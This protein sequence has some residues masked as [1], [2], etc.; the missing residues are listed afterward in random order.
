MRD[1]KVLGKT[2]EL[3]NKKFG[4]NTVGAAKTVAKEV[5][6]ISTEIPQIDNALII[7]GIPKGRIT[8]IYGFQ[9]VGKT[10]LSLTVIANT[11]KR[12]LVNAFVDMEHALDI[13]Y[14]EKLGVN[15]DDL[16]LSQPGTAEEALQVIEVLTKSGEVDI[17]WLDSVAA[18]VPTAEAEADMDKDHIGL[19]ARLVGKF[20]RKINPLLDKTDTSLVLLN[21]VRSKA[22]M[23][24]GKPTTLPAGN[25]LF[26][27]SSVILELSGA[28]KT[29]NSRGETI[30]AKTKVKVEKNK[31]GVQDKICYFTIR[32]GEGIDLVSDLIQKAVDLDIIDKSGSWLSYKETRVQGT[33]NLRQLFLNNTLSL[34]ELRKA[35]NDVKDQEEDTTETQEEPES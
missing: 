30:S 9:S 24:F 10:T 27:Y 22:G 20:C 32:Y 12:G 26:F 25:A 33:E 29:V 19:Q 13:K 17:I 3:L 23:V 4:K 6:P 14:A 1:P 11:Q 34:E 8:Q 16:L 18:L 7:G 28:G 5:E 2:L 21:Q 31:V 35:I 15:L